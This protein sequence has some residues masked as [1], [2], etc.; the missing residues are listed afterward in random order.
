MAKKYKKPSQPISN[1]E[2]NSLGAG[3]AER[4]RSFQIVK[5]WDDYFQDD[6][7]ENWQRLMKD[8]GFQEEFRSK[9]Q[10]RNVLKQVWINIYDFLDAVKD[11]QPVHQFKT[12]AELSHYTKKTGRVYPK[13]HIKKGS[14][15]ARLM[16][17]IF[18]H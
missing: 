7:L 11:G 8:L 6:A 13:K 3:E 2:M 4:S 1:G 10:C 17:H 9:T 12:E 18:R 16:A 5:R 14:P 15:L